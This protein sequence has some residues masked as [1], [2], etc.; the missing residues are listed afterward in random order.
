MV[1][2]KNPTMIVLGGLLVVF[3]GILRPYLKR[4][5]AREILGDDV[6][7]QFIAGFLIFFV[8]LVW[9]LQKYWR[10]LSKKK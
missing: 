1:N 8:S 10:N 9:V 6:S 7:E 4:I 5:V 2:L 3:L